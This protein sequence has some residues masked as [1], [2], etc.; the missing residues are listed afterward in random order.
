MLSALF[1]AAHGFSLVHS[2]IYTILTLEQMLHY[3]KSSSRRF[4]T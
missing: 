3:Y 2:G 1:T 4:T